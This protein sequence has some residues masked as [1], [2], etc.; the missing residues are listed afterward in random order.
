MLLDYNND[1]ISDNS[2]N[3]DNVNDDKDT[4]MVLIIMMETLILLVVIM[5]T[6]ACWIQ[7]T[8]ALHINQ[9]PGNRYQ[10]SVHTHF[11]TIC[12]FSVDAFLLF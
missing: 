5:T 8:S 3:I 4:L 11:N 12:S 2:D 7:V 1:I 9:S 10:D 6:S